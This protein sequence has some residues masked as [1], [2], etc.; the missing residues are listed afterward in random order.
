M[1]VTVTDLPLL[2]FGGTCARAGATL[3]DSFSDAFSVEANLAE[4]LT[5]VRGI[6]I[7]KITP[8]NN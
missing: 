4:V 1:T 7:Y 2:V 5:Q 8:S 3:E 6:S